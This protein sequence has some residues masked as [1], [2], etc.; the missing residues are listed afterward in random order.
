MGELHNENVRLKLG[1]KL[2][3]KKVLTEHKY[4]KKEKLDV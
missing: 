1:A 2:C 3:F 4:G